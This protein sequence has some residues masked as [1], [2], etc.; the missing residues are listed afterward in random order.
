[1]DKFFFGNRS[2]EGFWL[3]GV[4]YGKFLL[5]NFF[6]FIIIEWEQISDG[7][8]LVVIDNYS[9]FGVEL[10]SSILEIIFFFEVVQLIFIFKVF[11]VI[12]CL[13]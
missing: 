6:W 9:S 12:V 2:F 4:Y 8:D 10:R 3:F 5:Q 13:F 7:Y 1:M 11:Y